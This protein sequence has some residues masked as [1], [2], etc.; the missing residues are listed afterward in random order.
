VGFNSWFISNRKPIWYY[1]KE[2][3]HIKN[4]FFTTTWN[5]RVLDN[6]HREPYDFE[7]DFDQKIDYGLDVEWQ[8]F[9]YYKYLEQ[10]YHINLGP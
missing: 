4:T 8:L 3:Y 1:D 5:I 10:K 9:W 7:I 6:M 2:Y